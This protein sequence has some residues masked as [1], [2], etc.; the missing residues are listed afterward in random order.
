MHVEHPLCPDLVFFADVVQLK[1]PGVGPDPAQHLE[2]L[3]EFGSC[4][5]LASL[6]GV[7]HTCTRREVRVKTKC[8]R[9]SVCVCVVVCVLNVALFSVWLFLTTPKKTNCLCYATNS[10]KADSHKQPI[11][12]HVPIPTEC[13]HNHNHT[14]PEMRSM[15]PHDE[16]WSEP[17]E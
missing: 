4:A 15:K 14:E 13:S 10:N 17:S 3:E 6:Q 1:A 7:P 2:V 9:E 12:Y 11:Q 8:E 16:A 5:T